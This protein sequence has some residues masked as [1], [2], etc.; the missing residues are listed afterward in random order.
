[1]AF[2]WQYDNSTTYQIW[3]QVSYLWGYYTAF[4]ITTWNLPTD[5][6]FWNPDSAI[7]DTPANTLDEKTTDAV[8]WDRVILID[9]EDWDK[10]KIIDQDKFRWSTWPA[11]PPWDMDW[12]IYDP[13]TIE[14]NLYAIS[15]SVYVN[16]NT[17]DDI[18]WNG[19][20]NAPYATIQVAID[21][22]TT[23]SSS[24]IFQV[25]IAPWLYEEQVT[26]KAS[27]FLYWPW[28]IIRWAIWP[29]L[30]LGWWQSVV[31]RI[32]FELTPTASWQSIFSCADASWNH[33]LNFCEFDVTSSTNWIT[34]SV[35]AITD[36]GVI[37]TDSLTNYTMTWTSATSNTHKILD[38]GW[39]GI[40]GYFRITHVVVVED[41]N[42]TIIWLNNIA[43]WDIVFSSVIYLMFSTNASFTWE[44]IW[45]WFYWSWAL[46]LNAFN[47]L[48]ITW[49]G[50]GTGMI[51]DL[52]STSNNL[53]I[54]NFSNRLSTSWF[55]T[56]F[57]ARVAS[58]D[59][60]E[61]FFNTVTPAWDGVTWA[62]TYRQYPLWD[63]FNGAIEE[64]LDLSVTSNWTIITA[65]IQKEWWWDLTLRYSTGRVKFDTTPAATISL[66]AWSDT[67]PQKNYVYI[68]ASNKTLTVSTS[69]FPST[70]HTPVWIVTCQSAVS[71]QTDWAYMVWL[72]QDD[73]ADLTD[74]WH[75]SHI[76]RKLRKLDAT[77]E[78][79]VAWNWATSDYITIVTQWGTQDDVYFISTSWNIFQLHS[80]SF[81]AYN[82]QTWNPIFVANDEVSAFERITN[83][84]AIDT[85]INW[86]TLRNNNDYYNLVFFWVVSQDSWDC[87]I[88]CNKPNW[89]YWNE[90]DAVTDVDK[91]AIFTIPSS[92]D[93]WTVFYIARITVRNQTIDSWTLS[94]SS[95]EDL[96]W[97]SPSNVAWWGW[98]WTIKNEYSDN[99]FKIFNV[100]DNTKELSFDVSWVATWN[101]RILTVPDKNWTIALLDDIGW[102]DTERNVIAWEAL[103]AWNAIRYWL[104]TNVAWIQLLTSQRS[105]SNWATRY[106]TAIYSSG[107][108]I[109]PTYTWD[110][111][112]IKVSLSKTGSPTYNI[113]MKIY[114][115]TAWTLIWT[116]SNTID[117]STLSTDTTNWWW[118]EF[119]FAAW[120][121]LTAGTTY[122]FLIDADVWTVSTSNYVDWMVTSI[123]G[124]ASWDQYKVD[125]TLTWAI[126]VVGWDRAYI[127]ELAWSEDITK[128]YKTDASDINKTSFKWFANEAAIVDASLVM[129]LQK[130]TNQSWLTPDTIYYLNWVWWISTSWTAK[131]WTSSSATEIDILYSEE[132]DL[133]YQHAKNGFITIWAQ[134]DNIQTY[135]PPTWK[136]AYITYCNSLIASL[137]FQLN[138]V[139]VISSKNVSWSWF[140]K[141]HTPIVVWDTD[142]LSMNA[143]ISNWSWN[144]NW[145]IV[146]EDVDIAPIATSWLY[147]VPAWKTYIILNMFYATGNQIYQAFIISGKQ[148]HFMWPRGQTASDTE[149]STNMPLILWPWDKINTALLSHS[150]YLIPTSYIN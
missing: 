120:V 126:W 136:V 35:C 127:L 95:T 107:Q 19:S 7:P 66:T 90:A 4:Q 18:W 33:E 91:T 133:S 34:A 105:V 72:W 29:L 41:E 103:S 84:N 138:W 32:R 40:F 16:T 49:A 113:S 145:F 144:I 6:N 143:A 46:N 48:Q 61:S 150:G 139:D 57:E 67:S 123:N 112:K 65:A 59:T 129:N 22:I 39:T 25:I 108:S 78:D 100:I 31:E 117:A 121:N 101:E 58:W 128:V 98:A 21:S 71:I 97:I 109:I 81:P 17:W 60:L 86:V 74:N 122:Y 54:E 55:T 80:H 104:D 148:V 45:I 140:L 149:S 1:M 135:T 13:D 146:D 114:S 130:D 38:V 11:W 15:N 85:D 92:L 52:D 118:E 51:I 10:V 132:K 47:T 43:S 26:V 5:S 30:T 44:M 23:A 88:Y 3:D 68:L 50:S 115:D 75:L 28:A 12:S 96:R 141:L 63:F 134:I 77:Y 102:S 2:V 69:S 56:N 79:W 94:I 73:I 9:W 142:I 24:N 36:W 14:K 131:I 82:M 99:E 70:E 8:A 147:T 124:S 62:W 42:D 37:V 53:T 119:T 83:L 93:K 137:Q 76:N 106:S 110:I 27:V 20:V 125:N 89:K 111:S 87:K 64:K 116:S